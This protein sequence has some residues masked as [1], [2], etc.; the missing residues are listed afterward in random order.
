MPD[1]HRVSGVSRMQSFKPNSYKI[2]FAV[3]LSLL[4][5]IAVASYVMS[6]RFAIREDRVIHTHQV[7]SLLK[8]I[9]AGT[10]CR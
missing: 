3:V 9:S 5:G 4:V 6:E 10:Q 8:T 1:D 7:I 2:A